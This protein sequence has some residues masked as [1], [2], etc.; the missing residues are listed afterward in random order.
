ME[1]RRSFIAL[2]VC[3]AVMPTVVYANIVW[4]SLYIVQGLLS[5]YI[6]L[7]GLIIEFGFIKFFA[8]QDWL[9]SALISLVMNVISAAVGF[10]LI[11]ISGLVTELLLAPF[12]GGTFQLSHWIVSYVFAVLCNVLIE[13]LSIKWIFKI[14]KSFWWLFSANAISVVLCILIHGVTLKGLY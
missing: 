13:G 8:K 10:L 1:K 9:K 4:P 11:P 2:A 6:I 7:A 12:D 5:W 3:L 14:R